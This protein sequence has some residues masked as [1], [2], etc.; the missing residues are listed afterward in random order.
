MN[1]IDF[2]NEKDSGESA[3]MYIVNSEPARPVIAPESP[4]AR[5][6]TRATLMPF[7]LAAISLSRTATIA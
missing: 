7:A 3:P 2:I 1:S 4:K 5:I 6:L